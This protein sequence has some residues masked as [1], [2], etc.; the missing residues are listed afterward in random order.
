MGYAGVE[1]GDRHEASWREATVGRCPPDDVIRQ[2]LVERA[3]AKLQRDFRR[4]DAIQADLARAG[5]QT[6]DVAAPVKGLVRWTTT[7]GRSGP[8]PPSDSEIY[9]MMLAFEQGKM[10]ARLFKSPFSGWWPR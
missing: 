3:I 10:A 6:F 8:N 7:D 2:R 4:A 1:L 5:V 9:D